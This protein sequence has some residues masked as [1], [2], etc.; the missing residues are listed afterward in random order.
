[1]GVPE[2]LC[3]CIAA[4]YDGVF[5]RCRQCAYSCCARHLWHSP[6]MSASGT[7]FALAIDPMLRILSH[8]SPSSRDALVTFADDIALFLMTL[9]AGMCWLMEVMALVLAATGLQVSIDKTGVIPMW[10]K[11]VEQARNDIARRAPAA[12]GVSVVQ[13]FRHLGLV[14]GPGEVTSRWGSTLARF[15][16]GA[17]A[18]RA[19]QASVAEAMQMYNG[20]A[21]NVLSFL[22]SFVMPP[23]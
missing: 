14:V 15:M 3:L 22:A 17:A 23:T 9:L 20:L 7:V 18:V 1:M 10:T 8:C 16:W 21:F 19:A 5:D 13:G 6:K 11:D 4:L 2:P 12:A